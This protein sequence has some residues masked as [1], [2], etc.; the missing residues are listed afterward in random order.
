MKHRITNTLPFG[1]THTIDLCNYSPRLYKT[2]FD[3]EALVKMQPDGSG[4]VEPEL[5][6]DTDHICHPVMPTNS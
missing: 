5:F 3:A 1:P 4:V 6:S 2:F